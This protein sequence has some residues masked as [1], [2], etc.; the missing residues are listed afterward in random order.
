MSRTMHRSRKRRGTVMRSA[1]YV[2][3]CY[4][5]GFESMRFM[6]QTVSVD[7]ARNKPR[8]LPAQALAR[9]EVPNC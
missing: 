4:T 6:T 2:D 9:N 5:L 8:D 3:R 1:R 7:E